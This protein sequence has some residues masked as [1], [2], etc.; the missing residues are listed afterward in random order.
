[1]RDQHVDAGGKLRT[2]K[3][4]ATPEILADGRVRL[5]EQWQWTNG[6]LSEGRS[7]VEELSS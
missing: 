2:G 1:M 7:I 3:C 4:R 5:H 6:D